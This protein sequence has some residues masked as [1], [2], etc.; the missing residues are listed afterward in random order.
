MENNATLTYNTNFIVKYK[1]IESELMDKYDKNCECECEYSKQDITDICDKLYL[2]EL[3]SVFIRDENVDYVSYDN[4]VSADM[5]TALLDELND[6]CT[7]KEL[8]KDI[9]SK[10]MP[11]FQCK[12]DNNAKDESSL[13]CNIEFCIFATFFLRD[14]FYLTH[15]IIRH[16]KQNEPISDTLLNTFKQIAVVNFHEQFKFQSLE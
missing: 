2:D 12:Y 11:L 14:V 7:F 1:Q 4:I 8:F 9:K 3:A 5:I 6:I 10:L 16:L 15:P 13:N